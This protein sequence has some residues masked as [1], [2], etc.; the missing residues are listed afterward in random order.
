[1]HYRPFGQTKETPKD[2]VGYTG[3]KFDADIGLSYMQQRYYDPSIGRFYSNDS[4]GFTAKN[5]VMSFG[6]YIYVSNN[7]YKYADPDGRFQLVQTLTG[8]I[9]GGAIGA[10]SGGTGAALASLFQ[11][12]MP[13]LNSIYK[14]AANGAA[15]GAVAGGFAVGSITGDVVGVAILTTKVAL[16]TAAATMVVGAAT[17][18]ITSKAFPDEKM[19]ALKAENQQLKSENSGLEAK[20]ENVENKLEAVESGMD[21]SDRTADCGPHC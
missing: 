4:V 6:R 14:G 10:V 1:M 18:V 16:S 21:L 7:P 19:E 2:E 17:E 15:V 9:V 11:G 5:P 12:E 8:A 20:L 13:T 3:H